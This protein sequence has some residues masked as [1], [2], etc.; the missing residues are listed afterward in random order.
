[1]PSLLQFDPNLFLGFVL[2][3][4]RMS[5]LMV[6]APIFGETTVPPQVRAGLALLVSLVFYPIVAAPKLGADPQL[7]QIVHLVVVETGVGLLIGF[8]ARLLLAGVEMAG[9][10]AGFQMGLGLVN[11]V[12]PTFQNQVSLVAQTM[13]LFATLILVTMDGHHLFIQ[14]LASSYTLVPAGTAILTQNALA[15]MTMLCGQ[16][17]VIGLKV[18]A[19]LVVSVL[20]ANFAMGLMARSV[21]QMNVFV[22][23][24]PFTI[25]L[26]LVFLVLGFPY[27]VQSVAA[28]LRDL[29][30]IMMTQ[31][32]ALH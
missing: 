6:A 24:F 16:I 2:I 25:G 19:P 20:A 30:G 32:R 12:D 11:V 8:S 5:G 23:G 1:M 17:F 18:G 10:V 26:G 7:L 13:T 31:L 28:L 15:T 9:E 22:V 14:A 21:P 4:A 29:D 27:F 3:F